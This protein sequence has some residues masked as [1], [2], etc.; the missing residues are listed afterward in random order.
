MKKYFSILVLS[1]VMLAATACE[2]TIGDSKFETDLVTVSVEMLTGKTFAQQPYGGT[3]WGDT[4]YEVVRFEDGGRVILGLGSLEDPHVHYTGTWD[5]SP[6]GKV[7]H[8]NGL[9]IFDHMS[10]NRYYIVEGQVGAMKSGR[11]AL[12]LAYDNGSE[13]IYDVMFA[14]EEML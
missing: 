11:L 7:I 14:Y 4:T 1:I 5:V 3:S 6:D 12:Y 9:Q 8:I 2:W 13:V 10:G